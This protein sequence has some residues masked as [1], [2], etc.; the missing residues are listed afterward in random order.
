M[1]GWGAIGEVYDHVTQDGDEDFEFL[2]W[3]MFLPEYRYENIQ[4]W[5]AV[6]AWHDEPEYW[7][8]NDIGGYTLSRAGRNRMDEILDSFPG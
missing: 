4:F 7:I 1:D 5:E 2:F 6:Q 3:E 8:K